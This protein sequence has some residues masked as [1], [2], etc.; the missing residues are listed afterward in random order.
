MKGRTKS[1][2]DR[3]RPRAIAAE[4]LSLALLPDGPAR[5]AQIRDQIRDL[6][7][8]G[9]LAPG[10][11]LP[12]V[13]GLAAQLGVNPVTVARAYRELAEARVLEG[14]HGG[15]SF[16][17]ATAAGETDGPTETDTRP[18][19]AERLSE[20]G[21]APGV[22]AFTANYPAVDDAIR[23]DFRKSLTAVARDRLD[24]CLRYD[25]P[26][27]RPSLR[28]QIGAYLTRQGL[29]TDPDNILITAGGQQAIDLAVRALLGPGDPV[30]IEQP[31]YH[32]VIGALR[33]VRAAI[34]EVPLHNDGIDLDACE[35]AIVRRRAKLICVNPTFQNPTGITTSAQKRADLLA[36]ARRYGAVVLEDDHSPE[37]RFRGTA[38]PALR[39]LA[40]PDDPVLY[41]RGFGKTLLPGVRLG[42]L[43]FPE[44]L[45]RRLLGAKACADLHTNGVMQEAMADFLQKQS[46]SGALDRM[47][48]TYGL[49]QQRIY[50]GLVRGMPDGTLISRP[51][52][53]LSLW[54]TLPEGAD[55]A[56]LYF[57]AVHRGVAFVSGEVF[58]A[59]R[60]R[61]RSLRISFGLNTPEEIDEGVVRLCSVVEDVLTQRSR[62]RFVT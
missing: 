7:A 48:R 4:T 40:S 18:L 26:L 9:V 39:A 42:C 13:R 25:P 10:M 2:A 22:I 30:V 45:R 27:G 60:P 14:R 3:K 5:F 29:T 24:D 52:G 59:S 46:C 51:E 56:E 43:V 35:A 8:R 57:R 55:V 50:D 44:A 54:L 33:G 17:T 34:V 41:A 19:L 15:G 61:S 11:R 31:A 21:R 62:D 6:V 28:H 16:V 1:P 53:G 20:L 47:R 36:L 58:H 32:G 38:V 37:L 23:R 12:P 49:R